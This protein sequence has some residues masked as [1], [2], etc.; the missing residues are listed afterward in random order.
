MRVFHTNFI[1]A[2][3]LMTISRKKGERTQKNGHWWLLA[4][5]GPTQ[6]TTDVWQAGQMSDG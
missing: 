4:G 1:T 3:Q 2:V 5:K 6:T